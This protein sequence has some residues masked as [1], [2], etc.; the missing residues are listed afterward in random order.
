MDHTIKIGAQFISKSD[1]W[2]MD[3]S[4]FKHLFDDQTA[5]FVIAAIQG[6]ARNRNV[7]L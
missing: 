4:C 6:T 2:D 5:A 7:R 3:L 1:V